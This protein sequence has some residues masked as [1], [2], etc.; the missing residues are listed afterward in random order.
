MINCMRQG[1]GCCICCS[2]FVVL[3]NAMY[4]D[5]DHENILF[6]PFREQN[7]TCAVNRTCER[8]CACDSHACLSH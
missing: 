3:Q 1:L 7:D 8:F 4:S 6:S 5:S 2:V